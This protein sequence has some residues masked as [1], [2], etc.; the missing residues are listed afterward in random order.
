[1]SRNSIA[2]GILGLMAVV[3]PLQAQRTNPLRVTTNGAV[4][5]L[6]TG[7]PVAGALIEFPALRRQA[8]T[9]QLGRFAV[10][11]IRPGKHKV[12]VSQLGFKT[13][14]R[15]VTIADSEPLILPLDPDPVLIKGIDVQI[16]RLETRRRAVGVAAH[17]FARTELVNSAYVNASE[18]VRM[19]LAMFPCPS[20]RGTCMRHRGQIVAPIVYI[21][22][23]RAFGLEE[24]EAYPMY[25]VYLVE[26]YD[27]GRHI[28][29]Y[30]T[31]FMQ[32][33]ARNS[34][35]LQHVILW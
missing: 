28:R 30:T 2:L 33:L 10:T 17:A 8:I 27:N 25:D 34:V 14:V 4:T 16:D 26:S 21:D 9:D 23:R 20:G 19:R 32:N 5:D 18:F 11:N 1:M 7:N 31:W 15:E 29:I 22:E 3:A 6:T 13:L 12:V 24:L 35:R